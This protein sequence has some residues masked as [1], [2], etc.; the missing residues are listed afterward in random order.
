MCTLTVRYRYGQNNMNAL[1]YDAL[2]DINTS[3][4]QYNVLFY[5]K[6]ERFLVFCPARVLSMLMLCTY[7]HTASLICKYI[8]N[9]S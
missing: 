7:K 6:L 9:E 2:W 1:Q 5:I 4:I 8:E 3:L